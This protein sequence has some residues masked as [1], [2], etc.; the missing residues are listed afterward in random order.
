MSCY[1]SIAFLYTKKAPRLRSYN[2][3]I[4]CFKDLHTS[5]RRGYL[6]LCWSLWVSGATSFYLSV[7][8]VLPWEV[9]SPFCQMLSAKAT[10][11]HSV[12]RVRDW[13][14]SQKLKVFA[15]SIQT[16]WYGLGLRNRQ[17]MSKEAYH[18]RL[19]SFSR[20]KPSYWRKAGLLSLRLHAHRCD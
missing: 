6:Y 11:L 10:T 8:R 12:L 19:S 14:F 2:A 4:V 1:Y 5:W 9:I 15:G 17:R 16:S 20:S 18:R 13:Y 7:Q 3:S